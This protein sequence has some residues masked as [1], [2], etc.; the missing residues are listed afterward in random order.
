MLAPL[1]WLS[2]AGQPA[3]PLKNVSASADAK[4]LIKPKPGAT[5]AGLARL[6]AANQCRIVREFPALRDVQV[7]AAPPQLPLSQLLLRYRNSGLVEYA[8]PN[9]RVQLDAIF[10]NDPAFLDGT[11]WGLNNAGQEGGQPNADIDAPEAWSAR[12][13]ASNVIVAVVDSGIRY[14]HEDLAANIWTSPHDGSHGLNAVAGST[15]PND[16]LG[17]GTRIAGIIGAAGNNSTGVVG[18]AWRV[19]LMACKFVDRFGN[20]GSISE[21]LA[22]LD[23][24]RSNGA[25][26]I[27]ASWGL[28]EFSLSLSNAMAALRDSGIL[29][30]T[31]AGNQARNIDLFPHYPACYDLDNIL[32]ATATTRRDTLYALANIGVTNVDLAAPGDEVFSTDFQSDNSYA[33]DVGSSMAAAF[34]SGA[35]ALLLAAHAAESP[36]QIISRLLSS[37][38]PLAELKGNCAS[39]GR[40]NLR[41]ALGV[42]SAP[43]VL[44]ASVNVPGESFVLRLS[45]D[46]G[47][48][49]VIDA[50]RNALIWSPVS[51][52]RSDLTGT[53]IVTN[54]LGAGVVSE[55]YRAR[56]SLE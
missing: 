43:P 10:P 15:E 56:L 9:Y 32:V 23:Y 29:V 3:S 4:F 42:P 40:L 46:P 28:D 1:I 31:S 17:H 39:G 55:L 6:H 53:F 48:A 51:T 25:Q 14:T 26:I 13:S 16:D 18:L 52:N 34:A 20:G 33:F 35:A 36:A 47:R 41:K 54:T 50:S 37:V 27:N 11:L 19:Q 12:T 2:A 38:D 30:A 49:Y 21:A 22:C 44:S 45:G 5:P 7:L 24:A 8:E